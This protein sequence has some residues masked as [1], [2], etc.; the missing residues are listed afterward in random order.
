MALT[1]TMH[2]IEVALSDVDRGVYEA[3][4]LRVAQHPSESMRYLLTRTL[5]TRRTTRCAHLVMLRALRVF[6][7]ESND[8][9]RVPCLRENCGSGLSVPEIREFT[10]VYG[11]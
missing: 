7:V 2:H 3:L 8:D 11:A 6:A 4:D 10:L 5:A 9:C 1:A